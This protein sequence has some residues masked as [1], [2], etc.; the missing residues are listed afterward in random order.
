ME[1]I[2]QGDEFMKK[3][4]LGLLALSSASVFADPPAF[5]V[6]HNNVGFSTNA[7]VNGKDSSYPTGPFE[8]RS[9][10]GSV[11]LGLC[12]EK[13]PCS[14]VIVASPVPGLPDVG[15]TVAVLKGNPY[16][17]VFTTEFIRSGFTVTGGPAPGEFTLAPVTPVIA[18]K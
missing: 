10:P 14:A 1:I 17:G 6:V 5:F 2:Y 8:T 7:I 16:T 4:L 18:A 11:V 12:A 9:I 15:G 13:N 3:L